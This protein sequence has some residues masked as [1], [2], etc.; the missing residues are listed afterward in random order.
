M[1]TLDAVLKNLERDV[2]RVM[3][4]EMKEVAQNA[5]IAAVWDDV[6]NAYYPTVY[7]RRYDLDSPANMKFEMNGLELTLTNTTPPNADFGGT[8]DKDLSEVIVSGDGYDYDPHPGPRPF[9]QGTADLLNQGG[10][11][12]NAMAHGLWAR[13]WDVT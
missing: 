8:T 7:K 5:H 3:R 1:A 4:H 6:Y 11:A 9:F 10:K 2:K 12:E 13:G